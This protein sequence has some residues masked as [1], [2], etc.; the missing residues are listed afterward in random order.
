MSFFNIMGVSATGMSAQRI[1][2]STISANLANAQTTKTAEGGPYKR[3]DVVFQTLM[4]GENRGGVKVDRVVTDQKAPLLKYEPE[5]PDANEEGYVAYPN[6]NPIEE[7]VNMLDASRNYEANT[8]VLNTA[9]Q[10]A[11]RALEI[12]KA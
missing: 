4:E 7:M 1:R 10:L 11:L 12:G 5:H 8:T 3:K 6:V 2:I 9:K